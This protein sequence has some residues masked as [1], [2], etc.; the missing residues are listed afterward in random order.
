VRACCRAPRS[1]R[2]RCRQDAA[3]V[4]PDQQQ[5]VRTCVLVGG[6]MSR[7]PLQER[8]KGE[9]DAKGEEEKTKGE[10]ERANGETVHLCFEVCVC[11]HVCVHVCEHV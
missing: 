5:P 8:A 7:V 10:E 6:G 2:T 11:V 4:L 3:A 9:E 1:A